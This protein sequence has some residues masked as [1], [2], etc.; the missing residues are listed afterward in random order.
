[1]LSV[2]DQYSYMYSDGEAQAH[3][4]AVKR[5]EEIKGGASKKD[6]EDTQDKKKEQTGD[7]AGK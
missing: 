4:S 7:E 1:M 5:G 2:P 6:K 3:A